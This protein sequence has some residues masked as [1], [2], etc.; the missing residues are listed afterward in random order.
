MKFL[1][2]LMFFLT[3]L[4]N[5][6]SQD[7][8]V[9]EKGDSLNCKITQIKSKYIYFTF[10]YENEIRNTLLPLGQLNITKKNSIQNRKSLLTN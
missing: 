2:T 8:I 1:F 7:L 6:R 9:T 4:T 10:K 3:Y 5:V